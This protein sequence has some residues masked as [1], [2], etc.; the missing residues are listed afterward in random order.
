MQEAITGRTDDNNVKVPYQPPPP[1][2]DPLTEFLSVTTSQG[3]GAD[4]RTRLADGQ[5]N[6]GADP[7]L[8]MGYHT[9]SSS[10]TQKSWLRFDLAAAGIMAAKAGSVTLK[11]KMVESG[12]GGLGVNKLSK[13]NTFYVYGL[14]DGH[15]GDANTSGWTESNITWSNAPGNKL[16]SRY[17]LQ[18]QAAHSG[19]YLFSFT[20]TGK[21]LGAMTFSRAD[22]PTLLSFIQADTNGSV[23][24]VITRYTAGSTA[25]GADL[26]TYIHAVASKEHTTAPAPELDVLVDHWG[27]ANSGGADWD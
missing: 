1:I 9:G 4:A 18:S 13:P 10:N 26:E 8:R 3:H 15:P 25:T 22:Y 24:F 2:P 27:N 11:L 12:V 16:A 23:T 17:A 20:R 21:G 5:T 7:T 19:T 6:F 14:V